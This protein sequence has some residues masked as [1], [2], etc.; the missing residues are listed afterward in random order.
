[1]GHETL[2]LNPFGLP[3]APCNDLE[4]SPQSSVYGQQTAAVALSC[5][6]FQQIWLYLGR[7]TSPQPV[8]THLCSWQ[9]GVDMPSAIQGAKHAPILPIQPVL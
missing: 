2:E 6:Q 4:S 3:H 9:A 7:M 8:Y 5:T 1:M